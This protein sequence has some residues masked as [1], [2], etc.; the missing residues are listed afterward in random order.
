MKKSGG[1]RPLNLGRS[2]LKKTY[3]KKI[4]E[5]KSF[6][7]DLVYELKLFVFFSLII[8]Q[9][10]EEIIEYTIEFISQIIRI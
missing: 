6:Q 7:Q 10:I 3:C 8:G 2:T 1:L 9:D 4:K 5:V